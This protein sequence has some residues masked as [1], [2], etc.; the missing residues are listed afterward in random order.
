METTLTLK[1]RDVEARLLDEMIKSGLFNTKSEAVRSAL[2]KY[3]LDLGLLRR[4][5]VWGK[6]ERHK[7]RKVSPRQLKKDLEMIENET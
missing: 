6:I 4:G 7:K 1:F 2:V 3:G 5:K